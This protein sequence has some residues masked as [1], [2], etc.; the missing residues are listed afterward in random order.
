MGPGGLTH[1]TWRIIIHCTLMFMQIGAV[2]LAIG[3]N[4]TWSSLSVPISTFQAFVPRP[5][6]PD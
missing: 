6:W 4:S 5:K 3:I 2:A 1:N